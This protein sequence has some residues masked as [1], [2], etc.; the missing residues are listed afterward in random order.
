MTTAEA[1][2]PLHGCRVLELG[3]VVAG[4]FCARLLADFGAEVVKVETKEGDGIRSIGKRHKIKSLHAASLLRFG[5]RCAGSGGRRV[6]RSRAAEEDLG[7]SLRCA[8]D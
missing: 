2:G 5:A 8:G 4:L 7:R 6:Q 3:F 1:A